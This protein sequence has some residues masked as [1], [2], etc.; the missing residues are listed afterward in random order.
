MSLKSFEFFF[1]GADRTILILLEKEIE[2]EEGK[3]PTLG[4]PCSE[5][6]SQDFEF[7]DLIRVSNILSSITIHQECPIISNI[8]P[9]NRVFQ[10]GTL[11]R[12]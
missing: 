1:K 9:P 6:Q 3:G 12:R 8:L 10:T 5:W 7:P 2:V 11:T 4:Y